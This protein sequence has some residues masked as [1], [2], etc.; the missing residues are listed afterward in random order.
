LPADLPLIDKT[1]I[2]LMNEG[3]RLKGM[4]RTFPSQ[5]LS[6]ETPKLPIH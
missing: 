1:E 3:G 6:G 2:S 4:I 5:T